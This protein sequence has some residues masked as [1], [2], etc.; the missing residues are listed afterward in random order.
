MKKCFFFLAVAFL[1]LV[2]NAQVNFSGTW[3]L[4]S[5]ES[6]LNADFTMAPGEMIIEQKGNDLN[7]EKHSTFQGEAF[8]TIDKLTL[9]GKECLN[10]GMMDIEKKSTALWSDDKSSVKVSSKLNI[11]DGGEMTITEL[12]KMVGSSLILE[13]A[14]SSSFGD[15]NEKMVFSKK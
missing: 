7:I 9:D 3:T 6:T 10:Q 8:T 5:G 4:N 11:G 14:S 2:S 15:M 13:S 1:S 12:Y